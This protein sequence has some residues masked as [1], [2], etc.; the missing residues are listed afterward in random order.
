M[1]YSAPYIEAQGPLETPRTTAPVVG[2]RSE[3][4]ASGAESER[5]RRWTVSRVLFRA[6]VAPRAVR[7]IRLGDT[8]LR[9]SSALTRTPGHRFR[10]RASEPLAAASLFELAPGGVCTAAGHPDGAW[11]LTPRFHPC[12]SR[13]PG[14]RRCVSVALSLGLP[15]V[16]VSDLPALWSPDF[17]PVDGPAHRRSSVHLRPGHNLTGTPRV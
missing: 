13:S 3:P 1:R 7:I 14:H 6:K 5:S 10:R 2:P 12:L 15:R 11:A 9:R 17:P 8:L 16:A 4:K